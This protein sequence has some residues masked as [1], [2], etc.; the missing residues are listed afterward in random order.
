MLCFFFHVCLSSA[1]FSFPELFFFLKKL[2]EEDYQSSKQFVSG[3]ELFSNVRPSKK[4]SVFQVTRL[5]KLGRVGIHI[6]FK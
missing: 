5:K 2:F 4:I 6:I 1:D 3:S